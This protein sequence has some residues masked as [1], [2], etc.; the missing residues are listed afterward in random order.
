MK[1]MLVSDF[2]QIKRSMLST[3][4][5]CLFIVA[6]MTI[7]MG[8]P[9]AGAAAV[10]A[11]LPY[12][13]VY[14]V[15]ANDEMA[16]WTRLRDTLPLSRRDIVLGRYAGTLIV[17]IAGCVLGI[18]LGLAIFYLASALG[19]SSDMQ[20]FAS[21]GEAALVTAFTSIL[22]AAGALIIL[23]ISLPLVMRLGM[24]RAARIIPIAFVLIM[25]VG[26]ALLSDSLDI[27]VPSV[28]LPLIV[29]SAIVITLAI[30]VISA[31]V[32]CKL[33]ETREF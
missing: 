22:G 31:I 20:V 12:M 18:V 21:A 8:T 25:C 4:L 11:M 15:L 28:S 14:A 33:Y 9:V 2:L 16:G 24:T 10:A 7:S 30:F 23:A 29:A 27:I 26:F 3:F 32:T 6:V 17:V 5:V 13:T 19:L 1:L